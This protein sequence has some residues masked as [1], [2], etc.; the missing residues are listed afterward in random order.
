MIDEITSSGIDV[1][2]PSNLSTVSYAVPSPIK[3]KVK[4]PSSLSKSNTFI[5]SPS[6]EVWPL[7]T[8]G[9]L[10][11]LSL[12]SSNVPIKEIPFDLKI[13]SHGD[14]LD[15]LDGLSNRLIQWESGTSDL[16]LFIE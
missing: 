15:F 14:G 1:E 11:T 6:I 9:R 7:I 4:F 3:Q 13:E 16:K 12:R 10:M 8:S 2:S 5:S